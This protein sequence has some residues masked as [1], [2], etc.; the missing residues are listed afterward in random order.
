[1]LHRK[2]H[3]QRIA[4]GEPSIT[5]V[6]AFIEFLAS[7]FVSASKE[8]KIVIDGTATAGEQPAVQPPPEQ[9]DRIL[10]MPAGGLHATGLQGMRLN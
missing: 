3:A 6:L 7:D 4:G 2:R 10:P 9:Q 8:Q 5:K 1:L